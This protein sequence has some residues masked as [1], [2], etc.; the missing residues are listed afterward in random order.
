MD[1]RHVRRDRPQESILLAC[2]R[3]LSTAKIIGRRGLKA[4][5]H[6]GGQ[7]GFDRDER[8]TQ[9][10]RQISKGER[11]TTRVDGDNGAGVSRAIDAANGT[12]PVQGSAPYD[13][14]HYQAGSDKQVRFHA[15][16]TLRQREVLLL[17]ADELVGEYDG[18]A[19]DREP[20]QRYVRSIGDTSNDFGNALDFIRHVF[21]TPRVRL[22]RFEYPFVL[23]FYRAEP[24]TFY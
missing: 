19:R 13:Q 11:E 14:F 12:E 16:D 24:Y 7:Q 10:S 23:I 4:L 21:R 18:V 22:A 20:T 3:T 8:D 6:L 15:H 17:L 5:H 1:H 9:S 2:E